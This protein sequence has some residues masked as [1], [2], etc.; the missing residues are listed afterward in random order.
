MTIEEFFAELEE[1]PEVERQAIATRLLKELS[2]DDRTLVES[3]LA[4]ALASMSAGAEIIQ[5]PPGITFE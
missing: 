2:E 1:S 3:V 5:A 4:D